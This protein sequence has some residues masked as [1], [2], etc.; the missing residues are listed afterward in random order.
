MSKKN[1]KS[2][3]EVVIANNITLIIYPPYTDAS[4]VIASMLT[5]PSIVENITYIMTQE[6]NLV[7]AAAGQDL[8]SKIYLKYEGCPSLSS[9]IS[10]KSFI[11]IDSLKTFRLKNMWK[12]LSTKSPVC[13][14]I[15]FT[16]NES[17]QNDKRYL[18]RIYPNYCVL[19]HCLSNYHIGLIYKIDNTVMSDSQKKLYMS[20]NQKDPEDLLKIC[21]FV[22]PEKIDPKDSIDADMGENGWIDD[23]IFSDLIEYSPKFHNL[24]TII[25]SQYADK[26]VVYTRFIKSH[27]IDLINTLLNYLGINHTIITEEN[28]TNDQIGKITTFC[29]ESDQKV[30]I[31][32][33]LPR[34][35][36]ND[37]GHIHFLE[38]TEENTV[39]SFI[40][41]IYKARL[42]TKTRPLS[43]SVHCHISSYP[44]NDN[45]N[46]DNSNNDNSDENIE[47]PDVKLYLKVSGEIIEKQGI[48]DSFM[49]KSKKICY[50]KGPGI[51][52]I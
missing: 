15:I 46:N 1:I 13:K 35:E 29:G 20:A 47:T 51:S 40:N 18:D 24:L 32:N 14:L 9:A 2:L 23:S 48:F 8:P 7:N 6:I 21:N 37:V 50:I 43:I 28:D 31:M 11:M 22:Y 16:S 34:A 5:I 45:S 4:N 17:D 49:S 39:Y 25:V 27:G 44:N 42:F 41:S 38:G 26:H 3:S 19:T 30:L 36:I 12:H 52:V 10:K 33:T